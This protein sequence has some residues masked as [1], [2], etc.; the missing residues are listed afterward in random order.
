MARQK[1]YTTKTGPNSKRTITYTKSGV[2]ITHS[3]RPSKDVS[4][5]TISTN[6]RTGKSRITHSRKLGGGWFDISSKTFGGSKRIGS[7]KSSF[8]GFGNSSG[9]SYDGEG[10]TFLLDAVDPSN[11]KWWQKILWYIAKPFLYT[12]EFILT[13][14]FYILFAFLVYVIGFV[15]LVLFGIIIFWMLGLI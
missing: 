9:G 10:T 7:S 12:I 15:A 13:A 2:R 14:I 5:R 3:N 4:R 6:L 11:F 1:R 8:F